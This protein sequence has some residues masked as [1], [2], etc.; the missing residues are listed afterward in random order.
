MNRRFF[1]L[2]IALG[3]VACVA[4]GGFLLTGGIKDQKHGNPYFEDMESF[5]VGSTT[6]NTVTPSFNVSYIDILI[7][8]GSLLDVDVTLW[9]A[10]GTASD[11]LHLD[12]K[13]ALGFVKIPIYG[14]KIEK[15]NVNNIGASTT[16]VV[17][18]KY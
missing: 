12:F 1:R 8:A 5:T 10:G 15:I 11:T 18:Y 4:I 2:G 3:I 14:P 16:T 6:S 17:M 7:S 13:S 9:K